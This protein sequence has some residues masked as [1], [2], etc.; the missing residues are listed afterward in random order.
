MY[1]YPC[2]GG[3]TL[4]IA[5]IAVEWMAGDHSSR[6]SSFWHA[7]DLEARPGASG[8]QFCGRH[9]IL[10]HA[11]SIPFLFFFSISTRKSKHLVHTWMQAHCPLDEDEPERM[12]NPPTTAED[13]A[14]SLGIGP[15]ATRGSEDAVS[16]A[17]ATGFDVVQSL[18][19]PPHWGL[20][21]GAHKVHGF[22]M[23]NLSP[24]K[25]PDNIPHFMPLPQCNDPAG[26][27]NAFGT[28]NMTAQY[29][30]VWERSLILPASSQGVTCLSATAAPFSKFEGPDSRKTRAA[31]QLEENGNARSGETQ[32]KYISCAAG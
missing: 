21:H 32:V 2:V 11:V 16:R 5:V 13:I 12:R 9:N 30:Q 15:L 23:H 17:E 26:P 24:D 20:F 19:A 6:I 1:A 25:L 10:A 7:H 28:G 3:V 31:R 4:F 22:G 27:N 29:H 14:R 18:I 8:L